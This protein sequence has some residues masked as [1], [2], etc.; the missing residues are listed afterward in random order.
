MTTQG[1]AGAFKQATGL[2]IGYAVL[3]IVLGFL[4]IVLPQA[5]GV[6]VAILVAWITIFGGLVHLAYAFAAERAGTF[7][8]RLLIGIVYVVGG[9]YLAIN[10]GLS[11]VSLTLVLAGI[12]FA[13]GLLRIV[14][15]FQARSVPGAGWILVDGLLTV[16]LGFLIVRDWPGS[17]AWA[18]GTI[19]GANLCVSG[20][21]RLMLSVSARRALKAAA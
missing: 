17:S 12:F 4:A 11:L 13:E 9:I 21:T 1:V 18:I 8:W 19:V 3:M 14:L 16:L 15:F 10:P 20:V 5:T 6:G 7:F 2:S